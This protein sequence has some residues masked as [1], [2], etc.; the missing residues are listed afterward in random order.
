MR[1]YY[2]I[3]EVSHCCGASV[4]NPADD[5]WASCNEC[6]EMAQVLISINGEDYISKGEHNDKQQSKRTN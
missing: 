3:P 2:K 4:Y 1:K 6:K 5:L